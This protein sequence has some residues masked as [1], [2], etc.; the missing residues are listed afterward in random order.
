[1]HGLHFFGQYARSAHTWTSE[2]MRSRSRAAPGLCGA[3]LCG[4]QCC[5]SHLH[6]LAFL[7]H[8]CTHAYAYAHERKR[9]MTTD[10]I[11][12]PMQYG[13]GCDMATDVIWSPMQ[14]GPKHDTATDAIRPPMQYGHQCN[15]ATD[16]IWPP[17]QYGAES[18]PESA[19]SCGLYWQCTTM[20]PKNV[21]R[22]SVLRERSTSLSCGHMSLMR[23][24]VHASIH[25]F[26]CTYLHTCLHH[27]FP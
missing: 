7:R 26:I 8:A 6:T 17:M 3:T 19:T 11:W 5:A 13:H 10:A 4:T 20:V 18:T 22:S 21:S 27:S 23:S 1:M 12:P 16:A 25:T 9:N 15:M 2:T 14:Y 24:T